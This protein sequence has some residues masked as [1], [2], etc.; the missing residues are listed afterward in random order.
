LFFQTHLEKHQQRAMSRHLRSRAS[1]M[2]GTTGHA[3]HLNYECNNSKDQ[4][5]N[6][7][8]VSYCCR[9]Q[10]RMFHAHANELTDV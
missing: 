8:F 4:C 2:N 5:M 7:P 9:C 1:N 3:T 10:L 6:L